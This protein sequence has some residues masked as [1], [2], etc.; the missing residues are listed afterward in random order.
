MARRLDG[1]ERF[2]GVK[3]S[4]CHDKISRVSL[5]DRTHWL[6][7]AIDVA[8][9]AGAHA[10]AC[11]ARRDSLVVHDKGAQDYVSA[12]DQQTEALIVE[13]LSRKFPDHAFFGEE[14]TKTKPVAGQP[15][16]VIDP[17]DGTTNFLR[18]VPLWAISIALVLD[19]EPEV[20]VIFCPRQQELYAA[21][22]GLGATLDGGKI[23][24]SPTTSLAR[25]QVGLGSSFRT[26]ADGVIA[27]QSQL[28]RH[29]ADVRRLGS[30]CVHMAYVAAGRLDGY[31]ELHLNS[32][33]VAAG[34]VLLREAGALTNDYTRGEWLTQ[35][36]PFV[37]GA[38]SV[39]PELL[40]LL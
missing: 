11:F 23:S 14:G 34:L 12:A 8:R 40:R 25:A 22:R 2:E 15:V 30:A 33:D 17:I 4:L 26:A 5:T 39:F 1:G 7:A 36:N 10:D 20:G 19:N 37:C 24:V 38:P 16:W 29:G 28:T 18:G 21:A 9:M 13:Q 35:G 32:W 6:A 31:L 27:V 3:T